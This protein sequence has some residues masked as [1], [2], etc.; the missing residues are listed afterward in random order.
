M[1]YIYIFGPDYLFVRRQLGVN[2]SELVRYPDHEAGHLKLR[3]MQEKSD[4]IKHWETA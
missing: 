4:L 2:G 1:Q 3:L